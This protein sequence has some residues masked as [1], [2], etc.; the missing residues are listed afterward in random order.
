MSVKKTSCCHKEMEHGQKP[1]INP[2]Q[3][4]LYSCPMH[5]EIRQNEPGHC[6]ICGMNLEALSPLQDAIHPEYKAMKRRF[7]L[8]LTLTLPILFF[9]M[10]YP[11]IKA[12][13]FIQLVLATLI[14]F[15]IGF[16]FLERGYQSIKTKKL[17]MFTL[18]SLSTTIA[19]FYSFTALFFTSKADVPLYFESAAVITT[20]VLLGQVLEL[21]A[22]AQTQN[23]LRALLNLQPET[24]HQLTKDGQEISIPVDA[25]Q[26]GDLLR[27]RPGEK[28]PVDGT[29]EEG[30][31]HVDE[32]MITGE[33]MPVD[34][35]V[36]AKVI[37]ATLNT[38]GSFVM[39]ASHVGKDTLLSKII[40]MV[41]DAKM[42]KAPIQNLVDKIAAIFVPIVVIIALLSFILWMLLGPEPALPHALMAAISVFIIACPCALGLAT[43]MSIMVGIGYGAQNGILIKNAEALTLME[44]VS[45]LVID[46]TG[47]VTEGKPFLTEIITCSILNETELLTLAASL[48]AH[49]EHPQA[50]ALLHAAKQ[51]GLS[52]EKVSHF[53]AIIGKGIRG[54]INQLNI[55]LGSKS[56]M[57]AEGV[58]LNAIQPKTNLWSNQG[59][60]IIY[61]S[62]N[63]QLVALFIVED[64]IKPKAVEAIQ[65][66]QD[67]RISVHMLSGDNKNTT[68]MIARKLGITHVSAEL[69]PMDKA[70]IIQQLKQEGA[71]VAMAGDGINDAPALAKADVGIAMG[72]GTDVAIESANVTLL[73]GDLSSI[74]KLFYLSLATVKN[75]RQNLFL[76][77]IYN[78]LAIPL[79]AG[80][81]YPF[82]GFLLS[83]VVAAA[84]MSF[85]SVSVIINALRLGKLRF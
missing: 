73:Y 57:E 30:Q 24:A 80:L 10:L 71:V 69:S 37:G 8:A 27:V 83:P 23:A 63:G 77:F 64:P 16:P 18:I 33:P 48:E 62:I 9:D 52:L 67:N 1:Q 12:F 81:L 58:D 41:Y 56:F 53:N 40:H 50:F 49:S 42:S 20:L 68:E 43:P 60:S 13:S 84:T 39:K 70:K 11:T 29:L 79:A 74:I 45:I 35:R 31:S 22:Q 54:T 15:Y 44:K 47:T 6:P 72:T 85:S 2:T 5:P 25:I 21:K 66:L 14:I 75:M 4:L 26:V 17:N 32:S 65:Q 28:I 51:K 3:D 82:T 38:T 34:K 76:A 36:G 46:K 61:M 59:A 19:W 55:L 78:I 7:L